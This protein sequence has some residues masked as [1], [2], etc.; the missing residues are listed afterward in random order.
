MIFTSKLLYMSNYAPK[1]RVLCCHV[2]PF[3]KLY[4]NSSI[5]KLFMTLD[6]IKMSSVITDSVLIQ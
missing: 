3:Y 4:L 5:I 6:I 2:R 1:T